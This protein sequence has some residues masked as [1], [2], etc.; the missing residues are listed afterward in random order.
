M[1]FD[2]HLEKVQNYAPGGFH[3]I[4][5]LTKDWIMQTEQALQTEAVVGWKFVEEQAKETG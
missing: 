4:V 5:D 3:D 1:P 2:S